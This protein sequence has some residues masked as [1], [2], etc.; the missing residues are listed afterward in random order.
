MNR[1]VIRFPLRT[2]STVSPWKW[3]KWSLAAAFLVALVIVVRFVQIEI[4]TS[5]LQARY[6]SELG[7]DVAF[8]LADG[9]ST[10]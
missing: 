10:R 3:L 5:R 9:A 4:Q 1:P 8:T 2:T 6:L 7:R